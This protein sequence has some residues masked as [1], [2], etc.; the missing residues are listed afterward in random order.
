MK[1][2]VG[3]RLHSENRALADLWLRR[4]H[5][6]EPPKMSS[7]MA[8]MPSQLKPGKMICQIT[9][10]IS[11]RCIQAG[12]AIRVAF[13]PNICDRDLLD[14]TPLEDGRA[15]LDYWWQVVEGA[16]AVT[17]HRFNSA[18]GRTETCQ[19]I[20]LP[21]SDRNADGSRHFIIH[22]NWRPVGTDLLEGNVEIDFDMPCHRQLSTFKQVGTISV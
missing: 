15:R 20:G 3:L 2:L 11:L 21:F 12:P 9:K 22:T 19:C 4:W 10:G 13:G 6:S 5:S 14:L 8:V 1:A 17:Y 18:Q 7:F 16:V